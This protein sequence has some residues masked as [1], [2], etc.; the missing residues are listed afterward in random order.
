MHY[1]KRIHTGALFVLFFVTILWA[2]PLNKKQQKILTKKGYGTP[3]M[4]I[5]P[6]VIQNKT[7]IFS[8][9]PLKL[10]NRAACIYRGQ[11]AVCD[12]TDI[13]KPKCTIPKSKSP[14]VP[15]GLFGS[16]ETGEV[17]WGTEGYRGLRALHAPSLAEVDMIPYASTNTEIRGALTPFPGKPLVLAKMLMLSNDGGTYY[18]LVDISKN[19]RV[20]NTLEGNAPY[21]VM[22]DFGSGRNLCHSWVDRNSLSV[23]EFQWVTLTEQGF[24][25]PVRDKF[26]GEMADKGFFLWP[27]GRP[28]SV[29]QRILMGFTELLVSPDFD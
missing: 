28:Y 10:E 11:F 15:V 5:V 19:A 1:H 21:K 22:I 4:E 13:R 7:G 16:D 24:S 18:V 12:F 23:S 6:E 25:E 3:K 29:D 20:W 26:C 9:S 27:S 8:L 14:G 17:F 2:N